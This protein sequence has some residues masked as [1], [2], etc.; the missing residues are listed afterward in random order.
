[1]TGPDNVQQRRTAHG[2]VSKRKT[3]ANTVTADL[4]ERAK[5]E[6]SCFYAT[7]ALK[8]KMIIHHAVRFAAHGKTNADP[9]KC[10]ANDDPAG[11]VVAV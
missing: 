8:D 6:V 4:A 9:L 5:S 3:G 7:R 10:T 2:N 1:V 11:R